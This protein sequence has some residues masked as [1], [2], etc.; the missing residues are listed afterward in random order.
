MSLQKNEL[1][2]SAGVTGCML[3][4]L[5]DAVC[6]LAVVKQKTVA[7]LRMP[8]FFYKIVLQIEMQIRL[9][10]S[11]TNYNIPVH[12]PLSV[13]L[14]STLMLVMDSTFKET[15]MYAADHH[16]EVTS[17]EPN[18]RIKNIEWLLN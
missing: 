6:N 10:R 5:H 7:S 12:R 2:C 17:S 13:I 14:H 3:V 8:Q 9:C 11:M 16:K 4:F 18:A 15:R 1:G